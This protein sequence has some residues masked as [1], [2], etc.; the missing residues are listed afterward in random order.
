MDDSCHVPQPE[1]GKKTSVKEVLISLLGLVR[2]T[3]KVLVLFLNLLLTHNK[4]VKKMDIF[5]NGHGTAENVSTGSSIIIY[6]TI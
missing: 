4:V 5:L 6:K 3:V 1:G 2:Y